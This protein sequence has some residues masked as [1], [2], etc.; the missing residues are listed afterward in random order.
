MNF[1]LK[2]LSAR[3]ERAIQILELG[4]A[5]VDFRSA[6]A[7]YATHERDGIP[8]GVLG[9]VDEHLVSAKEQM[10]T[11]AMK[12]Q[13]LP[14]TRLDTKKLPAFVQAIASIIAELEPSNK[15]PNAEKL[16]EALTQLQGTVRLYK[17]LPQIEIESLKIEH[18]IATPS[19]LERLGLS[20]NELTPENLEA[21]IRLA[22][23]LFP[24]DVGLVNSPEGEYRASLGSEEHTEAL[25]Q[26]G[27]I[28]ARNWVALDTTGKISALTG[29]HARADATPE[30]G[31]VW[32]NWFG[33]S[34]EKQEIQL[35]P[36]LLQWT[37]EQARASGYKKMKLLVKKEDERGNP[38][39]AYVFY[40][41]NGFQFE[42]MQKVNGHEEAVMSKSLA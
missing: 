31:D 5:L 2:T 7:L 14:M 34:K 15:E 9:T 18:I 12:I 42:G 6:C 29:L 10:L 38:N 28:P 25:A 20:M 21:A 1:G 37:Q 17:S 3:A 23:E 27:I 22:H 33:V 19:P 35:G 16:R 8:A 26:I 13:R 36:P 32:L 24:K 40:E 4:K 30:A 11:A 41:K 39:R